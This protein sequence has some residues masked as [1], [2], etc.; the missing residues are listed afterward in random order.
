MLSLA[1]FFELETVSFLM[2]DVHVDLRS[3]SYKVK[4]AHKKTLQFL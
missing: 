1:S 2:R 4:E 3:K